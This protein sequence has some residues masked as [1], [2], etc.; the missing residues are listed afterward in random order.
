[1]TIGVV[2][3]SKGSI[4][5]CTDQHVIP[6]DEHQAEL[7]VAE[8]VDAFGSQILPDVESPYDPFPPLSEE[9]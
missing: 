6:I 9:D 2:K 8:L 4:S 7:L 3:P 5:I 1:M